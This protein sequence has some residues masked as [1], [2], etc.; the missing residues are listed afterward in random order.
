MLPT[1]L[2]THPDATYQ[3]QHK[4]YHMLTSWSGWA[5]TSQVP[6]FQMLWEADV[7]LPVSAGTC[8]LNAAPCLVATFPTA[9]K[10]VGAVV[11]VGLQLRPLPVPACKAIMG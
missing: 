5:H 8:A 1:N 2:E 10:T 11:S 4:P 7:V 6:L 3:H 9:G